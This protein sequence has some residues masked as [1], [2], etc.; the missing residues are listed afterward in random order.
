MAL[1]QWKEQ[2]E[3][4]EAREGMGARTEGNQNPLR[5]APSYDKNLKPTSHLFSLSILSLVPPL[6][7]TLSSLLFAKKNKTKQNTKH[8]FM[9]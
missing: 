7:S 1:E 2:R 5:A 4:E 6:P 9:S 3:A 8:Y